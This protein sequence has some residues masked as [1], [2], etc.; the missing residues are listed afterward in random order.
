MSRAL[1]HRAG[2]R[3]AQPLL[4]RRGLLGGLTLGGAALLTGCDLSDD[5]SVVDR[6]LWSMLRFNDAVQAALFNPVRLA[7]TYRPDQIT[8]P[9]RFNAFYPMDRVP[10]VDLAAWALEVSGRVQAGRRFTLA[11]LNAMPQHSQITRHICVEGWSQIG[12]W[13]G[14]AL[15][16][17]LVAAGADLTA[18]YVG[19]TCADD[20]Y[21]SIDMASALHPQ[22][23]LALQFGQAPLSPLWGA[24]VRLRI[25]TKLGFKNA[26]HVMAITVTDT[27][28]G[29][30]WE[31]Q[32]YNWFSG[33]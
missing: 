19:F 12:Q 11:D 6:A 31:D 27:N 24:P 33:S 32:G 13:Q 30:Y 28:P 16:D 29:G 15:R 7:R 14:V 10:Q 5:D 23:I 22:T 26:K 4:A 3:A 8:S 9:F 1:R 17:V 20:Y 2:L 25:P 21:T 18:R